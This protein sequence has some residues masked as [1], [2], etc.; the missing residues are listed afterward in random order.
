[1]MGFEC[2]QKS[3]AVKHGNEVDLDNVEGT[4]DVL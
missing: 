1:M 2:K 3:K 4:D